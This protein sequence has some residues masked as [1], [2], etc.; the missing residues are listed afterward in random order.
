MKAK[1][2]RA[3]R[4]EAGAGEERPALDEADRALIEALQDDLAAVPRPF[5]PVAARCGLSEEEVLA[6]IRRL[7]GAGVIRRFGATLKHYEV[8]LVANAMVVWR[9]EPERLEEVGTRLASFPAVSHCY[10]RATT[11]EWPYNLYTMIHGR[12][13]RECVRT[14]EE[15]AAAAGVKEY[16]LLFT[17]RELKK[18]KLRYQVQR[19]G[20]VGGEG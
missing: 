15:M 14:A 11:P 3:A 5:A 10:A 4:A 8:G 2:V 16:Q 6:R 12:D 18:E 19:P 13:R 7:L 17:V 9:V 20:E 1:E